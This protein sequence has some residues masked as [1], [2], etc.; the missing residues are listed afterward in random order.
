MKQKNVADVKKSHPVD[1][2]TMI[3]YALWMKNIRKALWISLAVW[4]LIY[5]LLRVVATAYMRSTSTDISTESL[6]LDTDPISL[7][8]VYIT[9]FMPFIIIGLATALC[10]IAS[11]KRRQANGKPR[12]GILA[13]QLVTSAII[14]FIFVYLSAFLVMAMALIVSS[15]APYPGS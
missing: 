4:L 6:F 8:G 14:M 5:P 3:R 10:V 11:L 7:P 1:E 12:Y 9:Y 13:L 2:A 15:F